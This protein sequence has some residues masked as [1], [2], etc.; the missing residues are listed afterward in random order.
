[1]DCLSLIVVLLLIP[2]RT[3]LYDDMLVSVNLPLLDRVTTYY[4]TVIL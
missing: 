3:Y 4:Y 2:Y 1:M